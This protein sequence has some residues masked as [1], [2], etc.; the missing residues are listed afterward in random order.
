MLACSEGICGPVVAVPA[1][2]KTLPTLVYIGRLCQWKEVQPLPSYE[3]QRNIFGMVDF[4]N[5]FKWPPRVLVQVCND[6]Y[7]KIPSETTFYQAI[8]ESKTYIVGGLALGLLSAWGAAAYCYHDS[9][10]QYKD[11]KIIVD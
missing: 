9:S 7:Q 5:S 10:K 3:P 11:S 6:Q 2:R 4:F 1:W 8:K